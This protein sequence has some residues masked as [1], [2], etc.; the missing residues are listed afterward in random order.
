[1]ITISDQIFASL[2][3][4]LDARLSNVIISGSNIIIETKAEYLARVDINSRYAGMEVLFVE[5][6][7]TYTV[8][9]F[10]NAIQTGTILSIKYKFVT[11]TSDDGFEIYSSGGGSGHIIKDE[12]NNTY[13]QRAILKISGVD[14]E[15]NELEDTT[16]VTINAA[17]KEDILS[18]GVG[19]VGGIS[20]GDT[21][22]SGTTIDDFIKNL[23][24]S[25]IPLV[26]PTASLSS[27][28]SSTQ[29]IGATINFTLTPS[30][31]QND[32]GVLNQ[33]VFNRGVTLIQTQ[34][35]LTPYLDSNQIIQ[36]GNNSYSVDISYDEGAIDP[37]KDGVV[38]AG[39]VTG[40]RNIVGAYRN[41]F[42]PNGISEPNNGTEIRSLGY[43]Y[44]NS[45]TL[46]TGSTATIHVIAIPSTKN[47][48]SVIDLDALNANITN[49]YVLSGTLTIVPD[50][51]GNSVSYKV[52]IL[53][54][55]VPY[56]SNHRHSITIS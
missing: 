3:L 33:V 29:E 5:P 47:L 39:T 12:S 37:Q 25:L 34:S 31:N 53:T 44:N 13:P 27:S 36:A 28:P 56:S 24:Q 51:G 32:A 35:D 55:A 48:S 41:W 19:D 11:D 22:L 9:F 21:I 52:Y 23:V 42:G 20:E 18:F 40:N 6:A 7:G 16:E 43:S 49:S 1:M 17:T 14:I 10:M 15:D 50:G 45:F 2:G 8:A 46:N 4:P 26:N 54:I 38:P 30:F